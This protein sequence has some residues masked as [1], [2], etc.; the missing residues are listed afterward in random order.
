MGFALAAAFSPNFYFLIACRLGSGV[1]VGASMPAI[2]AL[3][4]ESVPSNRRGFY[5]TLCASFWMVGSVACA[6]LAW[7]LLGHQHDDWRPY[8]GLVSLPAFIGMVSLWWLVPESSYFLALNKQPEEAAK[9]ISYITDVNKHS[10]FCVQDAQSHVTRSSQYGSV[11]EE[12]NPISADTGV[13]IDMET[14]EVQVQDK[15]QGTTWSAVFLVFHGEEL[16][17]TLVLS[18]AYVCLSF[19]TYGLGI[20]ISVLF[21][22]VGLSD[23]YAAALIYAAAQLPGNVASALVMDSWGRKRVLIICTTVSGV[24][25]LLLA[26]AVNGTGFLS[27]AFAIVTLASLFNMFSNACWNAL[28]VLGVEHYPTNMRGSGMAITLGA[29]R[30]GSIAAQFANGYWSDRNEY[31]TMVFVTAVLTLIGGFV[32]FFLGNPRKGSLGAN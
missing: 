9:T 10:P 31:T 1:G 13:E 26:T 28:D 3:L 7:L 14:G 4:V 6:A 29:G 21:A 2:F 18:I 20:Y 11:N 22:G 5:V 30:L 23:P 19:G 15:T 12:Q 24:C 25:G 27:G 16:R 8:T 32:M 17:T